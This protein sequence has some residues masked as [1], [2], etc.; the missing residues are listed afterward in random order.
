MEGSEHV[1][2]HERLGFCLIQSRP[3]KVKLHVTAART[4][5]PQHILLLCMGAVLRISQ[6]R[7]RRGERVFK[8]HSGLFREG[9]LLQ[10]RHACC[11]VGMWRRHRLQCLRTL[12]HSNGLP[13][14]VVARSTCCGQEYLT[15]MPATGRGGAP[16][17]WTGQHLKPS[18]LPVAAASRQQVVVLLG[19]EHRIHVDLDEVLIPFAH[20]T[21]SA[22]D[23]GH[24]CVLDGNHPSR[25]RC[26]KVREVKQ[27]RAL[28]IAAL[29]GCNGAFLVAPGCSGPP[30]GGDAVTARST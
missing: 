15:G 21:L 23:G 3:S 30:E 9:R 20:L 1:S 22:S 24:L 28:H 13:D 29:S 19:L 8:A 18:S 10:Q 26:V 27:T 6:I 25:L 2:I 11:E 12:F 16:A 4:V 17:A 7:S 14:I 5:F